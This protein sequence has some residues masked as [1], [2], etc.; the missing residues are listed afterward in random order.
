MVTCARLVSGMLPELQSQGRRFVGFPLRTMANKKY[1]FTCPACAQ[2][3]ETVVC[4]GLCGA[5]TQ[6]LAKRVF[7]C[8]GCG[9]T[10]LTQV[11]RGLCSRCHARQSKR[12]FTCPVCRETRMTRGLCQ[13]CYRRSLLRLQTCTSCA[14][15]RRTRFGLTDGICSACRRLQAARG[16]G[17][18]AKQPIPQ[19]QRERGLLRQIAPLRRAWVTDFLGDAWPG[20]SPKTRAGCLGQLV[21]LDH[22]LI[23][24]TCVETG[25]WSLVS[26]DHIS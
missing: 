23:D 11:P 8:P 22:F 19:E 26:A 24:Q 16:T 7:S 18:P 12:L 1:L 3:K 4:K 10:R 2:T 15:T 21:K 5:C 25:Q 9:Q 17:T 13:P 6:R 14:Q 20:H